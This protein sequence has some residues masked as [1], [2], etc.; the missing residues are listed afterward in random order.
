[1]ASGRPDKMSKKDMALFSPET[2][3]GRGF[4]L[5]EARGL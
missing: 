3:T 5:R 1:V 4:R 2:G